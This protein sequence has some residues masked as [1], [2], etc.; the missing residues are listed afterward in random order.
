MAAKWHIGRGVAIA[1]L[2]AKLKAT[3]SKRGFAQSEVQFV[4]ARILKRLFYFRSQVSDSEI[5]ISSAEPERSFESLA[6]GK[7]TPASKVTLYVA[8]P[9]CTLPFRQ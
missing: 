9:T 7:N 4:P 3:P 8:D 1:A 5:A 6:M 2:V